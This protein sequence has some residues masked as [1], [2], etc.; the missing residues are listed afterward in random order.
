MWSYMESICH[1]TLVFLLLIVMVKMLILAR[2]TE[3]EQIQPPPF[4]ILWW[5]LFSQD[6]LSYALVT[7]IPASPRK[8]LKL[9]T[10]NVY[11]WIAQISPWTQMTLQG[12]LSMLAPF[13]R[14]ICSYG[15]SIATHAHLATGEEKAWLLSASTLDVSLVPSSPILL[16]KASYMALPS[17]KRGRTVLPLLSG[18]QGDLEMLEKRHSGWP[19]RH[20]PFFH[21]CKHSSS[22]PSNQAA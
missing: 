14:L 4:P 11:L 15:T 2:S 18:S 13:S 1:Q 7:N 16:G 17:K 12:S 19:H 6:S 20:S 5:G 10:V 21:S 8:P 22:V 3:Q 9:H